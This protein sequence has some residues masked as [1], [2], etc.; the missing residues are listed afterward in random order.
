MRS[1]PEL[2]R[3]IALFSVFAIMLTAQPVIAGWSFAQSS[4]WVGFAVLFIGLPGAAC[5]AWVD[6]DRDA[7]SALFLSFVTGLAVLASAFVVLCIFDL[8]GLVW[9][10]PL[11][12]AAAWIVARRRRAW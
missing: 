2:R 3:N 12:A 4:S 9:I 7:L 10:V 8:R 11:G 1:S 5:L 6:P